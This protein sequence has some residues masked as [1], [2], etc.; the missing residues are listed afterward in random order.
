MEGQSTIASSTMLGRK[1]KDHVAQRINVREAI[2]KTRVNDS[3]Y[4]DGKLIVRIGSITSHTH[5]AHWP[6]AHENITIPCWGHPPSK[7]KECVTETK[8]QRH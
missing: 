2:V 3:P 5:R 4:I 1:H 6:R 8:N 7:V